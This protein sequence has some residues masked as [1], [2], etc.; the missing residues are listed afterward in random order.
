MAGVR[1]PVLVRLNPK[2]EQAQLQAKLHRLQALAGETTPKLIRE[3]NR[4]GLDW[5]RRRP[6]RT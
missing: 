1:R 3:A 4:E 2:R 5:I 6:R